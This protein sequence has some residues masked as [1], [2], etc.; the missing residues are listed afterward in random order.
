LGRHPRPSFSTICR[1]RRHQKHDRYAERHQRPR[2]VELAAVVVDQNAQVD[3]A[4]R[5]EQERQH[6]IGKDEPPKSP[7][8]MTKEEAAHPT[9][10]VS[11][12][13]KPGKEE[14]R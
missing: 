14:Q 3:G 9:E 4:D 1:H 8:A 10:D 11:R 13:P 5:H 2:E 12:S 7:S 6:E